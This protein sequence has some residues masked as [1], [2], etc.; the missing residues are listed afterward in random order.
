MTKLKGK[1]CN[2][3]YNQRLRWS[4]AECR[5]IAGGAPPCSSQIRFL[6]PILKSSLTSRS[7]Q[8]TIRALTLSD[9]TKQSGLHH[10]RI[11]LAKDVYP[12]AEVLT[13]Y[14]RHLCCPDIGAGAG[15]YMMEKSDN[16][17]GINPRPASTKSTALSQSCKDCSRRRSTDEFERDF[18]SRRHRRRDYRWRDRYASSGKT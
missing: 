13:P 14:G 12:D 6:L 11:Q 8:T 10:R 15:V 4:A 16:I 7:F 17:A 18:Q 9:L 5:F 3:D 1:T 2:K